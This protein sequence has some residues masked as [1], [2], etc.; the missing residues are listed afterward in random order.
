MKFA[1]K[2]LISRQRTKLSAFVKRKHFKRKEVCLSY[3]CSFAPRRNLR[4]PELGTRGSYSI[5][6]VHS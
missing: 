4:Q 1:F 6:S 5:L 3:S 2:M